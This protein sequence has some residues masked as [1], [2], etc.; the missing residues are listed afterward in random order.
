[1]DMAAINWVI[2]RP[3]CHCCSM[4]CIMLLIALTYYILCV[5]NQFSVKLFFKLFLNDFYLI[6]TWILF[7]SY[8]ICNEKRNRGQYVY[9][10]LGYHSL[11]WD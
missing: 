1:M 2:K 10:Y 7:N 3:E 4:S 9:L 8:V 6:D 11:T 5:K